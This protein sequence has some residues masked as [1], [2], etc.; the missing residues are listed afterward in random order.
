LLPFGSVWSIGHI[1]SLEETN[2]KQALL[3]KNIK[4]IKIKTE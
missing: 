2:Q 1:A 3:F 4:K